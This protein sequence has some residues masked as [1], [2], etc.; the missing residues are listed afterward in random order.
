MML[1]TE[2]RAQNLLSGWHG[3]ARARTVQPCVQWRSAIG[4]RKTKT[5]CV[6]LPLPCH[7]VPSVSMGSGT[8]R[9]FQHG[10]NLQISKP[11]ALFQWLRLLVLRCSAGTL[12]RQIYHP[13]STKPF[14][15]PT[16]AL[17]QMLP[18]AAGLNCPS[19]N[20]WVSLGRHGTAQGRICRTSFGQIVKLMWSRA[21]PWEVCTIQLPCQDTR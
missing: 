13:T 12:P 10:T 6:A 8:V 18:W 20:A 15:S 4:R 7:A 3:P 19:P 2:S 1:E 14:L 16:A 11:I 5:P 21:M 9:R 17:S